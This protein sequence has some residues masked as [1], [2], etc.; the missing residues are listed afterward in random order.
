MTPKEAG[1]AAPPAREPSDALGPVKCFHP[2]RDHRPELL[3]VLAELLPQL[4]RRADAAPR[5]EHEALLGAA[6][7]LEGVARG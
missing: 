1:R 6:A 7:R 3:L 2:T 5:F 4:R